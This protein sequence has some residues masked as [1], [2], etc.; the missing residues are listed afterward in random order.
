MTFRIFFERISKEVLLFK[1]VRVH[2]RSRSVDVD[3]D[4]HK[5]K[6]AGDHVKLLGS[7][8]T[9]DPRLIQGP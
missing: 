4:K 6:R 9:E 1:N 8:L 5:H 7:D 2:Q 3:C